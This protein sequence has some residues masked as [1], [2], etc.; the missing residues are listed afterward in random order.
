MI[1]KEFLHKFKSLY[2][3]KY[4][5]SLKDEEATEMATNFLNLMK[6]LTKPKAKR[7]ETSRAN[8]K[9]T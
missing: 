5:I 1:S 4:D 3:E 8:T 6:V 9:F 7:Y 2:K